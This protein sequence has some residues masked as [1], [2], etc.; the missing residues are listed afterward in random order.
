MSD[1]HIDRYGDHL[2]TTANSIFD[3]EILQT[4]RNEGYLEQV[5]HKDY[6]GHLQQIQ[7]EFMSYYPKWISESKL[8]NVGGLDT[9]NR[10]SISLGCTQTLDEFHYTCLREG[11]T[12]R[13]F[14]GE[15]PYNYVVTP[16]NY[17]KDFIDDRPLKSTDAVVISYPFSA[18]GTKH[19]MWDWLLK[20]CERLNIPILV[21][22]AFFGTCSGMDV[23]FDHPNITAVAFSTTKGLNCGNYR[24]GIR[25]S[26]V[27]HD[28]L[29]L[30][31]SWRHGIH[32]N[33]AIGLFFMKRFSP[34]HIFNKYRPYQEQVCEHYGLTPLDTVHL[35]MGDDEWNHFSRDGKYNRVGIKNAV[36]DFYN[37]RKK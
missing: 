13:M 17:E 18:T 25:F 11:R 1:K 26:K 15:Y 34:D 16:F 21:D 22:C 32:L 27:D 8:N 31:T 29:T 9:F 2:L 14:R 23:D 28:R 33:V 3:H 20:E 6:Y 37:K 24:S 35:A 5:L 4:L 12:L 19:I 30:Q 7:D 36:R 10:R